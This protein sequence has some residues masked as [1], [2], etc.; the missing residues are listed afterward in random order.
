M[1]GLLIETPTHKP[2]VPELAR[3]RK[4]HA[5]NFNDLSRLPN[6]ATLCIC[7]TCSDLA[8]FSHQRAHPSGVFASAR[9]YVCYLNIEG[10]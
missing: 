5:L 10:V 2:G 3:R 4:R 9:H 7:E 8:S 1:C 6:L